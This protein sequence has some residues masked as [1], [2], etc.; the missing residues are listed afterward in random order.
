MDA[1]LKPCP[2]CG[3]SASIERYGDR[4]QSTIYRCDECSCRLETGEEWDHGKIW[5]SRSADTVSRLREALEI[6]ERYADHETAKA[7][8]AMHRQRAV[9]DV[10][11]AL[12]FEKT[13]DAYSD[14][15]M[16]IRA[17]LNESREGE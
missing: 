9:Q 16:R 8:S 10:D 3:G 14:M 15:T 13:R 7:F 2:F 6:L 1:K 5:N 12:L 11:G 4:I 17:A